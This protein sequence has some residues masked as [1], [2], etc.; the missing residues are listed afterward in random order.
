MDK[1]QSNA[2]LGHFFDFLTGVL[3]SLYL[4]HKRSISATTFSNSLTN[5]V[6]DSDSEFSFKIR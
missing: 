5:V 6:A 3:S 2:Q 4:R 1:N